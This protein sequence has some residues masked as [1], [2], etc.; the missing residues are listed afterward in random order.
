[1]RQ[2]LL[3]R[4][5]LREELLASQRRLAGRIL[6]TVQER[7]KGRAWDREP[8]ATAEL[9]QRVGL[10]FSELDALNDTLGKL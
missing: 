9:T 6:R 7:G 1:M 3:R 2:Q 8:M 10:L 4:Q 5:Q